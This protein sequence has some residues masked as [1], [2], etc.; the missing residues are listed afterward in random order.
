VG[1]LSA[2]ISFNLDPHLVA[3]ALPHFAAEKVAA[4]EWSFD[5]LYQAGELPAWF[6]ELLHAYGDA[7]RL[8]GHGVYYSLFSGGWSSAQQEWLDQL[9][10]LAKTF[11]FD[12][13][14]EHFGF[15]TG[16]NFHQGA[17]L[18]IPFTAATLAIG[19][20]RLKRL[21]HA[22]ECPVGLENLAFCYSLD[23][24][25]HHGQFLDELVAPVNGFIILDLHNVYCQA[26]NFDLPAAEILRWY[27][28]DRVRE[29]HISGGSWE[30]SSAVAGKQIR[31]DTHDSAVPAAVFELLMVAIPRCPNLKFVVLEQL[32]LGLESAEAQA[33]FRNDFDRMEAIVAAVSSDDIIPANRFLPA[34]IRDLSAPL[35]D[36][37]LE[38]EQAILADILEQAADYQ[39]AR[40]Q[41]LN[42]PLA[43][44]PWQVE[45]WDP[46]MLET[47]V[48]IAK[49]WKLGFG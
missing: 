17:P 26:C 7:G 29:I 27:P 16:G 43:R 9:S 41:L 36:P 13:V 33:D 18:G 14:S 42:S 28:L 44:S 25:K 24:V 47:A 10:R 6:V 12:H 34:A 45:R 22:C 32:S 30:P 20:D 38:H 35:V 3:A 21:Y 15:M 48:A 1:K 23:D 4:I 31:R 49:K 2:A 39:D 40:D 11:R 46:A 8:V 37:Q 5:C 19:R